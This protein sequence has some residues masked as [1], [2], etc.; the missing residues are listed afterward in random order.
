MQMINWR[1]GVHVACVALFVFAGASCAS[2]ASR[3]GAQGLPSKLADST[4]WRLVTDVSEPGGFFR[5]DNFVSNEITFQYVIPELKKSTAQG[6]V[7]LGVGP[8]QNFTYIIALRPKIAFIFDI[9]RQNML[10]HLLYKALIER[11][12]DRAE[13]ISRLFS[14]PRP[15]KLD[16]NAS[17]DTL[18]ATF[19]KISADSAFFQ[20]NVA[21]VTDQLVKRHGFALSADDLRAIEYVYTAFF[22][23]GPELTYSFA[24]PGSGAPGMGMF[25]RRMPTFES[26]MIENDGQGEQRSYLASEANFRVLRDMETN[27]LLVPVVG[28]FAGDKAIRTVGQYLKQHN[29]TVTAFYLSNVE[30][31][32]FRQN[33]DWKKFFTNVGALPLDASSTFIRSVFNFSGGF[34]DTLPRG[35][36]RSTTMLASMAQQVRAFTDGRLQTY[37]DVVQTSR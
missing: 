20:K 1:R 6:G 15:P 26:L 17:A 33:D 37:F 24:A 16:G 2:P 9:R 32:L 30:Q 10:Q 22:I 5:S 34:R 35:G 23:G 4:F 3:A 29:A 19:D 18:F 27:N 7:Y 31:Y 12:A 11:S 21:M 36:P 28:D 25:G 13:F 14:R 8:D